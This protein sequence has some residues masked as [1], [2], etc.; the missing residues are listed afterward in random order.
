MNEKKFF[1]INEELY[2]SDDVAIIGSS[3]SLLSQNYAEEI[4][5]T[6]V[7]IRFNG[8][9]IKGYENKVGKKTDLICLGLDVAYYF[10]YPFISPRGDVTQC[11]SPNRL[12]NAYILS[13]LHRNSKFITWA[14]EEDRS[15]KNMQHAN[16]LFMNEAA[17]EE[18]VFTWG[19]EKSPIEIKDNYQG[20][21]ILESYGIPGLLSS[22]KGMRTGFRTTLMLIKS[23]IR[24]KLYGFDIDPTIKSALHYY[25]SIT[26]DSAE[27]HPSHDIKGEMAALIELHNRN[28]ITV[29]N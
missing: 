1:G 5:S 21:R 17:G 19:M 13:A 7:V 23:G 2:I 3:S 28:L 18:R 25:D 12:Q 16:A 22:G 10:S 24:P 14:D 4:N 6:D 29:R 20:N 15:K 8:A 26:L 11:D 9:L 27:D